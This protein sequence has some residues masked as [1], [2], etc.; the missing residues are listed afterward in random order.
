MLKLNDVSIGYKD[1]AVLNNV[2]FSFSPGGVYGLMAPNGF[3]K[4]TLLKTLNGD[5][6]LLKSG[7][8]T[9]NDISI[10]DSDIYA[11]EVYY[12]PEDNSILY[13]AMNGK[14]H[15]ELVKKIW[16]SEVNIDTPLKMLDALNLKSQKISKFSQGMKMQLQLAMAYVSQSPYI[17]LDEPL[18]ALD[19]QH[20]E[21]SSNLIKT[22]AEH[23]A[24]I[25]I[26]SHL[27]EELDRVCNSFIF[28][29]NKMLQQVNTCEES[30]SL[31]HKLFDCSAE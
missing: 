13:P 2:T 17:L 15:L 20:A 29:K 19:I 24:C 6:S 18:N 31:Y 26:S 8:I 1:K 11:Q 23:G 9:C 7:L 3:G 16:K 22:L 21:Y 25:I 14:F 4:S 30:R 12:S 27:P 5:I 28:I 10:I